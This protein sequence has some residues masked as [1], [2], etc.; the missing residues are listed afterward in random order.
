M[1]REGCRRPHHPLVEEAE[2]LQL[3]PEL[4]VVPKSLKEP[5][6]EDEPL[7]RRPEEPIVSDCVSLLSGTSHSVVTLPSPTF[8]VLRPP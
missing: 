4:E 1:G 6:E 7:G 8:P 3:G 2:P 5:K